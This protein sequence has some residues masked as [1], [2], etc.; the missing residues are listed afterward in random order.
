[1]W[2][3]LNKSDTEHGEIKNAMLNFMPDDAGYLSAVK[4][5]DT[6]TAQ[7]MVDEAAKAAEYDSETLFR[8][9]KDAGNVIS[10]GKDGAHFT[11]DREYA[12]SYAEGESGNIVSGKA[13]I[14]KPL[15]VDSALIES[16]NF[17]DFRNHLANQG[18]PLSTPAKLFAWSQNPKYNQT[19]TIGEAINA[20]E[21]DLTWA[22]FQEDPSNSFTDNLGGAIWPLGFDA[23]RTLE[24]GNRDLPVVILRDPKQ[25]KSADPI[26]RDD[27]GNVIPLSQR[28][29]QGSKDIR[30]MPDT[31]DTPAF[32]QWFG[33]SKTVDANGQPKVYY[34]GTNSEFNI[35]DKKKRKEG[36]YG[37]AFYFTEDSQ[38][39]AGYGK[40]VIPVYLQ[41]DQLFN[42]MPIPSSINYDKSIA[43]QRGKS[44]WVF[45]PTQIKLAVGNAGTFD[46]TNPD[47]RFMPEVKFSAPEK[48][49]NGQAWS[50]DMNYRVIQKTGGKYRIY[51]PT[52][53]LIGVEDTLEKSKKLIAKKSPAP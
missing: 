32:K 44:V 11:S 6:K 33:K 36:V 52:G 18:L 43:Y 28:F 26:T 34:H 3:R 23:I 42:G 48:L 47:I 39:A 19:K 22:D 1:M 53:A 35:F 41:A 45:E 51:A 49:P 8:G 37:K 24:H 50:T 27:A 15:R 12:Q 17:D 16:V 40:R 5:G 9:R 14:N 4:S 2:D 46:A 7:R 20:I 10:F 13:K 29:N 38:E 21:S 31:P 30:F 25:I